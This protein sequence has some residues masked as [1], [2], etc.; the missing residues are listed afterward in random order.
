V[1][2][3]IFVGIEIGEDDQLKGT[4][5]FIAK[6]IDIKRLVV[7]DGTFTVLWMNHECS[8]VKRTILEDFVEDILMV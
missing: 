6:V 7:E 3:E 1:R 8:K 4:P 5:F 2:S